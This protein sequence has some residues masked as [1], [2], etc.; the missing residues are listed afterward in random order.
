[1]QHR[2]CVRHHKSLAERAALLAAYERSGLTQR[3]FAAQHGIAL[4]T[5]QRWKVTCLPSLADPSGPLLEVPN[6]MEARSAICTYRLHFPQGVV[7]EV[8]SGFSPGELDTLA[9]LLRDL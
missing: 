8:S 9:H 7:L 3:E 2:S 4:S 6:L 1:M 5:L